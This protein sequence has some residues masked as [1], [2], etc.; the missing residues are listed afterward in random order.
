MFC[1]GAYVHRLF[2]KLQVLNVIAAR[3]E[4]AVHGFGSAVAGYCSALTS[5]KEE[6]YADIS[7]FEEIIDNL[8]LC[9]ESALEIVCAA[10]PLVAGD[11]GAAGGI[12]IQQLRILVT[13]CIESCIIRAIV[14]LAD[15]LKYICSLNLKIPLSQL[16]ELSKNGTVPLIVSSSWEILVRVKTL[17]VNI[18]DRVMTLLHC[19]CDPYI[20]FGDRGY[21][22]VLNACIFLQKA[23]E[24]FAQPFI[25]CQGSPPLPLALSMRDA[26]GPAAE[27]TLMALWSDEEKENLREFRTSL[28]NTTR[29]IAIAYANGHESY[30]HKL[31]AWTLDAATHGAKAPSGRGMTGDSLELGEY[32]TLLYSAWPS[33]ETTLHFFTSVVS[34]VKALC[35][36]QTG[37]F[38]WRGK[39]TTLLSTLSSMTGNGHKSICRMGVILVAELA[40]SLFIP[41]KRLEDT[42]ALR[43][44]F[45]LLMDSISQFSENAGPHLLQSIENPC[46][47]VDC[48]DEVILK[49]EQFQ[50]RG[51]LSFRTKQ[52]H[53][54]VVSLVRLIQRVLGLI[55]HLDRANST[56]LP[57]ADNIRDELSGFEVDASSRNLVGQ[58]YSTLTNHLTKSN[59]WVS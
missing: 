48:A 41:M 29:T 2:F 12:E 33:H 1:S 49:F 7:S 57:S 53:I 16:Q 30:Y 31:L 45:S 34:D 21:A 15:S 55:N 52:D 6:L 54:G 38:D 59:W 13:V 40:P 51:Q 56:E 23:S 10:I 4:H 26:L 5:R 27:S 35:E 37:N 50:Q 18:G 43:M 44:C 19:M 20:E 8:N 9:L 17:S 36:I 3:V 22:I 39:A 24:I 25:I 11:C 46:E 42:Y 14:T 47:A 32:A 28:R 58:F